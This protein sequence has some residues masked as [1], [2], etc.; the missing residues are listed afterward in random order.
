MVCRNLYVRV[1]LH[2]LRRPEIII[3][4]FIFRICVFFGRLHLPTG[5]VGWLIRLVGMHMSEAS[6]KGVGCYCAGRS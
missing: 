1:C 6:Y 4:I 2:N 5:V 3:Y